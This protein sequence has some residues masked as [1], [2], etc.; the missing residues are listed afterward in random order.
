MKRGGLCH[1]GTKK[2][3]SG[4][5]TANIY[6]KKNLKSFITVKAHCSM[7][8]LKQQKSFGLF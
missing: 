4:R 5:K 2:I 8:H 6:T 1:C 7:T 3:K